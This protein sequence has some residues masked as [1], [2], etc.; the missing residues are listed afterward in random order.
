MFIPPQV[1]EDIPTILLAED[2]IRA[3]PEAR[4]ILTTR[5][6]CAWLTSMSSTLFRTR[7][8]RLYAILYRLHPIAR[9]W[10]PFSQLM[11]RILYNADHS[12]EGLELAKTRYEEHYESVRRIVPKERLLEM[13]LGEGKEWERL[14][15]FLGCEVPSTPYPHANDGS[16]YR[17]RHTYVKRE[18]IRTV[19]AVFTIAI[20]LVVVVMMAGRLYRVDSGLFWRYLWLAVTVYGL[21]WATRRMIERMGDFARYKKIF[22]GSLG[23]Q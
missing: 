15:Q 5:P 7:Q 2:L 14:C 9:A 12:P 16:V 19:I 3:Y 11:A 17:A 1:T 4:V 21:E 10:Y 8:N 20:V 13:P 22:E 6:V 23:K 18:L